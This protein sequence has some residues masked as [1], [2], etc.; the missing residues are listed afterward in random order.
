MRVQ[1][2]EIGE[3]ILE[4]P[5][6]H[7]MT[8]PQELVETILEQDSHKRKPTWEREAE[9]YGAPKGLHRERKRE[10]PYNS[11]VALRCDIIDIDPS[12]YEEDAKRKN[13]GML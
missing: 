5:E 1:D 3:V 4:D 7:D 8:E 11:Y 10:K 6:Y 9:R 2:M 12:T 13:G